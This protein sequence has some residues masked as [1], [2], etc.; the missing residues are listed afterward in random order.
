MSCRRKS[1]LSAA[2]VAAAVASN[3][4]AATSATAAVYVSIVTDPKVNSG[5]FP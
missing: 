1:L 3:V 4:A 2:A 5:C